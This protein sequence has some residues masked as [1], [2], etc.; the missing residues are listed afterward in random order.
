MRVK[1]TPGPWKW[2]TSNSFLRLTG[3]D[4]QDGGVL[5]A[6]VGSSGCATVTVREGDRA[7]IAAAPELLEALEKIRDYFYVN[8]EGRG[9][10]KVPYEVCL[11][12]I[13]KATIPEDENER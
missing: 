12:A 3:R 1:P 8:G 5:H 13:K 2:W 11:A 10:K 7:L 9:W 6:S 4:G